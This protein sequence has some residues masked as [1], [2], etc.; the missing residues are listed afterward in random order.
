M[1]KLIV[2]HTY[3]KYEKFYICH[4][5]ILRVRKKSKTK[6]CQK[7]DKEK[8]KKTGGWHIVADKEEPKAGDS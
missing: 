3:S 1:Q 7:K 4:A 6:F 2:S 5:L 8:M